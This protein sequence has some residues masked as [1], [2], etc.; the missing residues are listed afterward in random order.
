MLKESAL[1]IELHRRAK[2]EVLE[3]Q[4]DRALVGSGAHCDVRLAPDEAAVE[5]LLVEARDE[6]VFVKV[7][8]F[9][10]PCR[11]NGAP[12]LEGRLPPDALIEFG[13]VALCVRLTELSQSAQPAQKA[14]SSTHPAV[15]ALGL[16]GLAFG[17]YFVLN[18]APPPDSA[19]DSAA[20]PPELFAER[21]RE[22]PHDDVAA[23]RSL[24]Q[25]DHVD[26]ENRRERSPFYPRDGLAA[27]PLY[28]RAAACYERAGER[29]AARDV[30][31]AA[32]ALRRRIADEFHVRQVRI[33][34]FIAQEKYAELR[35][36]VLLAAEFVQDPAH[37]Y[38]HWLSAL[39][40]ETEVRAQAR[41]N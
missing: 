32:A 35:R 16:L 41:G 37:P 39:A 28:E 23:A 8:S 25:Q 15:Q 17:F 18:K 38:A 19:L 13:P 7:Y 34:R 3:L 20:S 2:L 14:G 6:E 30:R 1:R 10:P 33:E 29:D 22:C 26:A 27:V 5:Q 9:D 21:P 40:R 24:A 12:F 4:T 31:D 11:L 36:E